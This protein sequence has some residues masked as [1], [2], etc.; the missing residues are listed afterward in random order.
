M[1]KKEFIKK[2]NNLGFGKYVFV[3]PNN[4]VSKPFSFGCFFDS[5]QL[6]AYGTDERGKPEDIIRTI[7]ENEGFECLYEY[8]ISK[9]MED[10]KNE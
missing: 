4:Y 6:I 7:S 9:L 3:K 10:V 1:I 8:M 5:N 2:I